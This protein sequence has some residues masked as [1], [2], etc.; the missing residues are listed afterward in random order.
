MKTIH[1]YDV[2]AIIDNKY[3]QNTFDNREE[4]IKWLDNNFGSISHMV[5]GG[6]WKTIKV[7][8]FHAPK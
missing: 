4:A 6:E 8:N 3:R 1:R 2:E 5:W 7:E